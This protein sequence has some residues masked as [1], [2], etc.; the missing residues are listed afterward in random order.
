MSGDYET[1][2][3]IALDEGVLTRQEADAMREEARRL[4]RSPLELLRERGRLSKETLA[5]LQRRASGPEERHAR[6]QEA[7]PREQANDRQARPL[8]QVSP[9]DET[10]SLVPAGA[11]PPPA[12]PRP[13]DGAE[14]SAFP[15]PGWDRYQYKGFLGQGGMGRQRPLAT[16][17]SPKRLLK[18]TRRREPR[19]GGGRRYVHTH[20]PG[21]KQGRASR[22]TE[23]IHGSK[24]FSIDEVGM[25]N[26]IS[27][28]EPKT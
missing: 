12:T 23:K 26:L 27:Q 6:P 16:F 2:I 3:W 13:G 4:G 18:T 22:P 1:E 8:E 11:S 15:V 25:G 14:G 24:L 19:R 20:G 9:L 5:S 17:R 10:A 28:K 7:A 21:W